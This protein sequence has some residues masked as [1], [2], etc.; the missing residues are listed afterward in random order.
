MAK[1]IRIKFKS[2]VES[3]SGKEPIRME[4]GDAGIIS[5]RLQVAFENI[6]NKKEKK[7]EKP[8]ES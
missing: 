8:K 7:D 4:G 1:K 5:T 2:K 6:K 3:K